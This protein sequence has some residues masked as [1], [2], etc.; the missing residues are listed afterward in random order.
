M[1]KLLKFSFLAIL[2]VLAVVG[3]TACDSDD[4]SFPSR[5][6]TIFVPFSAGG[7]TDL[8][9]RG[10]AQAA[11][12]GFPSGIVVENRTGAGGAVGITAGATATADGYTLTALTVESVTLP[13]MGGVDFTGDSFIPII[14]LNEAHSVISVNADSDFHTIEDLLNAQDVRVGNSGVGAIWHL[15]AA[16]FA[17]AS[18]ADF[19]HVP[20]EGATDAITGLLGNHIEAVTVSWPEVAAQVEAGTLRVL[21]VLA[22]ERISDIE[23][24]PTA[25]E[26]GFD[27]VVSAWRGKGV[28]AETPQEVVDELFDIFLEAAQGE[29]FTNFM[30]NNNL[31][32]DIMNPQ[33]FGARMAQD[34]ALFGE[35]IRDLNLAD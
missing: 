7:G 16:A 9:A 28:P 24:V 15:A 13:H 1:K 32:I 27:V 8:V 3:L 10:I 30:A 12:D 25:R 20:Y 21:A 18:G 31:S 5:R 14:M 23:H 22:P 29:Y 34:S 6:V 26:L 2:G 11:E 33:E 4:A 17:D 35:L 19:V